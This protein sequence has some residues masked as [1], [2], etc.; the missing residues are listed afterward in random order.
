MAAHY[1]TAL[2]SA[3]PLGVSTEQMKS[4]PLWFVFD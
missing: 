1:Q 3:L 4:K 2:S